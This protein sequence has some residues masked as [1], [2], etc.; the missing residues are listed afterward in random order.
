MPAAIVPVMRPTTTARMGT[1]M[2]LGGT[3]QHHGCGRL[4]PATRGPVMRPMTQL[5]R[6]HDDGDCWCATPG[7]R[8]A[9]ER[10]DQAPRRRPGARFTSP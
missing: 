1:T 5:A 9:T 4:A 10:D 8:L 2:A 7:T 3:G 6:T